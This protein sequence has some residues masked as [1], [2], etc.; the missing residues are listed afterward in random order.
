MENRL[1]RPQVKSLILKPG[2][3]KEYPC[4]LD[5]SNPKLWSLE[6]PYLHKLITTLRSQGEVVDRYET[7]FGI[8][9]VR[10]DPN[11]G[12]FLNGKHVAIKGTNNHQD[13]AGVGTA[14]PDALQEFRITRLKS[15][16]CN[17]YRCSHN[18]PTP[19][20]L[21]I[22]DRLGMLV[23]DENRLMGVSPEHFQQLERMILRDRNHPCVIAW[24]IGNE[25]WAI[26]GNV[27]GARIAATMQAFAKRLDPTRRVTAAISGGWGQGISTVIDLMG[28]NYIA[29]GSIDEH[30]GK[31]PSQPSMLTEESTTSATRG[32]YED[33][34]PNAAHGPVGPRL[35]RSSLFRPR[36]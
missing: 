36:Y 11:E 2:E 13:H 1:R 30:H 5:V 26:E 14:I 18:P 31:F 34:R 15:M 20:L 6:S 33:D 29:H 28:Y 9:S 4:V 25:E 27:K 24:S 35:F 22:C 17:A 8:R 23:L 19:E 3:T 10:F 16:G 12:L 21:D 32:V 7:N